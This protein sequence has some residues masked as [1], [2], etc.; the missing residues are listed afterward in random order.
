MVRR[1]L[2]KSG[3]KAKVKV[4]IRL[5]MSKKEESYP[6]TARIQDLFGFVMY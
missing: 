2:A 6:S 1:F 5:D 4:S 3:Q